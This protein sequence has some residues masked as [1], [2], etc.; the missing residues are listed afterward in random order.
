MYLKGSEGSRCPTPREKF[1]GRS[2]PFS[3][4]NLSWSLQISTYMKFIHVSDSARKLPG[5]CLPL[6]P[7]FLG[8]WSPHG[9]TPISR[10]AVFGGQRGVLGP[11]K[12][13]FSA[14]APEVVAYKN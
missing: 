4:R 12:T 10:V 5:D 7:G 14:A 8:P 9:L 2:I 6:S 3:K 13:S 1:L 11:W